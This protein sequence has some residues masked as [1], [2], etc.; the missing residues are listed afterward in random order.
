MKINNPPPEHLQNRFAE[1]LARAHDGD[2][3]AKF[4]ALLEAAVDLERIPEEYLIAPDYSEPLQGLRDEKE[5]ARLGGGG[6]ARGTPP[7]AGLVDE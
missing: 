1:P 2:H 7:L 4:E 3:L 5:E 6:A